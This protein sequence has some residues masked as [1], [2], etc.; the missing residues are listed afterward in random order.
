MFDSEIGTVIRNGVL[1]DL[2]NWQGAAVSAEE[3]PRQIDRLF[4]LLDEQQ[5]SYLLVGGVA[6]LSYIE[7]RNTQDIDFIM[8]LEDASKLPGLT[9]TTCNRDFARSEFGALQVDLLLTRNELFNQVRRLHRQERTFGSRTVP[10]ATPEG[11]LLLKLYALPSLYRQGRFDKVS[12]YENDITQLLMHYPSS[13]E[14]LLRALRPHL[15]VSDIEAID[16]TLADVEARIDRFRIQQQRL[17]P[18][19]GDTSS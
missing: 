6:L 5:I 10:C 8:S 4:E 15:L 12:I 16:A 7:G 11:L 13:T 2:K 14:T 9:I 3:L 1:F 17:Q 18:D 19:E